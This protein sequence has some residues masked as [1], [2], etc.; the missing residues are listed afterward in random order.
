M[1]MI[2]ALAVYY[3]TDVWHGYKLFGLDMS[4]MFIIAPLMVA[5]VVM[6]PLARVVMDKKSKQFAFRMGLPFYIIGGIMLAV[7]DPSWTPPILVPIV[8]LIMGLGFGGAQMMPWII[9][10]DT[11]DVAEMATGKRPTGTYS[12]MMTLARKVAGALGVGMVGWITGAAGYIENTTGD[13]SIYIEQPA[14]ALLAIKL[15]LG[16]AIVVFISIALFASFKYKVTSKKLE[17][18]RYFIEARKSGTPLTPEE[19][20]ERA[21]MVAELYGKV[22]PND[23]IDPSL[24]DEEGNLKVTEDLGIDEMQTIEAEGVDAVAESMAVEATSEIETAENVEPE[25]VEQAVNDTEE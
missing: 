24:Y 25:A 11:L 22:N 16:I 3:A 4:S 7:M 9:F 23:I 21:K 12:G 2:S 20:E 8:A 1:D 17:R 15:V 6:F 5:A 18:M 14:T 19:E 10:P 13:A